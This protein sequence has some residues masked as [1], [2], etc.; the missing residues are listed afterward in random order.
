V[1]PRGFRAAWQ[2]SC[3]CHKAPAHDARPKGV[4]L[5][6]NKVSGAP[7]F[8]LDN[9]IVMAGVPSIMQ[10]MLDEVARRLPLSGMF[11]GGSA[12][13][14]SPIEKDSKLYISEPEYGAVSSIRNL[15]SACGNWPLCQDSQPGAAGFEPGET[16]AIPASIFEGGD[17]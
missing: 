13:Q 5:V 10:A 3:S 4:D 8:W 2:A 11:A 1:K 7:G 17:D 6:L 14:H 16:A 12:V 9:I 15:V